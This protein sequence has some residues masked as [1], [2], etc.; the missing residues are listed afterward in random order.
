MGVIGFS[1]SK[2]HI[3]KKAPASGKIDINNNISIMNVEETSMNLGTAKQKGV[4]F[5]FEFTSK[6]EPK[7]GEMLFAGEILYLGEAKKHDEILKG[8]KKEKKVP[9][10]VMRDILNTILMRCNIE[11]MLL[12]REIN[13]PPPI[14][15]NVPKMQ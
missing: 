11:A 14:P 13:L 1:F 7:V 8:W 4:K 12:S 9:K 6:Y 2:M 5:S 3:E 15:L 10:E